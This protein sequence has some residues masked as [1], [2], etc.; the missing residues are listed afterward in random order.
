ML[1]RHILRTYLEQTPERMLATDACVESCRERQQLVLRLYICL[2]KKE[3][4]VQ[5]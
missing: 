2:E 1:H 4:Q 5:I 3:G